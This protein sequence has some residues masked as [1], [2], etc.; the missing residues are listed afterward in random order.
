VNDHTEPQAKAPTTFWR[1]LEELADSDSFLH[2]IQQEFPSLLAGGTF[3]SNRRQFLK[4][5]GAM[6]AMSGLAGCTTRPPVEQIVPYVNAPE[7]IVPGK[8][9]YFATAMPQDGYA[10]GVLVENHMGRPTKVEGNPQHPASLGA[11]NVFA[12][13]SVISLY[14]PDRAQV[15]SHQN[16]I[17]TWEAF[18]E[19][20]TPRLET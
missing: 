6:L 3:R 17:S 19:A 14:D 20:L 13:A 9:L 12:Q 5:M 16:N 4:L 1:S 2:Q 18:L 10:L 15:F 7:E 8:P 11:A